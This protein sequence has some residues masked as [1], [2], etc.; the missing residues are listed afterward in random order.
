MYITETTDNVINLFEFIE[1]IEDYEKLEF[2]IYLF[3]EINCGLINDKNITNV[4]L[5]EDDDINI[6]SMNVIGYDNEFG[7]SI[8]IYLMALYN[9]FLRSKKLYIDNGFV[10][11]INYSKENKKLY[12]NLKIYLL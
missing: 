11:G 1:N 12:Q 8:S 2:F 5:V 7:I 10:K 9:S 3:N 6:F 4:D